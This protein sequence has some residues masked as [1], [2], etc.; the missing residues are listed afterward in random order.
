MISINF[1]VNCVGSLSPLPTINLND[2]SDSVLVNTSHPDRQRHPPWELSEYV[3][4]FH[5]SFEA[6]H[7]RAPRFPSI[8]KPSPRDGAPCSLFVTLIHHNTYL[9]YCCSRSVHEC[10]LY[11]LV[12]ESEVV[13][14]QTQFGLDLTVCVRPQSWIFIL[15]K[16]IP[17]QALWLQ[18]ATQMY[19]YVYIVTRA[20][21][22]GKDDIAQE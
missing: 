3:D 13:Y 17:L 20:L 1:S 8:Y 9:H 14:R 18:T 10:D 4:Q 6:S 11:S 19:V 15:A 12:K 2:E 21:Y 16:E 5:P 7:R 22:F